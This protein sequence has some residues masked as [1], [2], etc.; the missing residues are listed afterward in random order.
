MPYDKANANNASRPLKPTLTSN[1][2]VKSPVT[3]RLA[4]VATPPLTRKSTQSDLAGSATKTPS[5][6]QLSTPIQAFLSNNVTPRSSSRKS[7]VESAQSTPDGTPTTGRPKSVVN[8]T[9]GT[10]N[11]L[12]QGGGGYSFNNT[13][14]TRPRSVIGGHGVGNSPLA[15]SSAVIHTGPPVNEAQLEGDFD[16][17]FFRANDARSPELVPAQKKAPTF[18]YANGQQEESSLRPASA[19]SP[20]LSAVST[21]SGKSQFFRANGAE[22]D[23]IPSLPS[24]PLIAPSP[25]PLQIETLH[26]APAFFRPASSESIHLSYRKGASQVIKP[27]NRA[28]AIPLLSPTSF[29]TS[30][31]HRRSGSAET[32]ASQPPSI[33]HNRTSSLSS[34]ESLPPSR[35]SSLAGIETTAHPIP[36]PLAANCHTS[37][38]S[39]S[40]TPSQRGSSASA[41]AATQD[42]PSLPAQASQHSHLHPTSTP[43]SPT[44]PNASFLELA[45][46]ARRERKVLDLEISNS[47]LL[48]I[49]RQ[50]EREVRKQK[51]EL[52]RFRRLTRAGRLSSLSI[53][54]VGPDGGGE[55][56]GDLS[57]F[58]EGG[59]LVGDHDGSGGE[60]EDE[61]EEEEEEEED[62]TDDSAILS[63]DALTERDGRMLAKD[64]KRLQLDL[65][66]HR[67]LLVDSQKMN[68]AL[69]R[70]MAW[71][72]EMIKEGKKALEYRVR[73]DEV[74]LGGRVL[75]RETVGEEEENGEGEE[76][77]RLVST[78]SPT[79]LPNL[80]ATKDGI[81]G[82][83]MVKSGSWQN[84]EL[85]HGVERPENDLAGTIADMPVC[86]T[87]LEA[88]AGNGSGKVL[89]IH[90]V[91]DY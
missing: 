90:G 37:N 61:E 65:R 9:Y 91:P 84:E 81:L 58:D 8:A 18:F 64:S 3:P 83:G 10:R 25:K 52:R 34:I 13:T 20:P 82:L 49:N 86:G 39:G 35:K 70:C 88:D 17:K 80:E 36:S 48:A 30:S 32:P 62:S 69:K 56:E 26:R 15:R 57:E 67:E 33:S 7:R 41:N 21:R 85:G 23:D 89:E 14:Q 47:S 42:P 46:N 75:E 24:P 78:W 28:N 38:R 44:K 31:G 66:R 40:S 5:R 4:A 51:A 11:G 87:D 60:E 27:V 22:I 43:H 63:P 1:R 6:E 45:A 72:E 19:P 59:E 12:G 71:T 2:A 29:Q 76:Q 53:L 79:S 16:A 77:Y 54:D 73:V 50:L 55:G 68:Q 74:K